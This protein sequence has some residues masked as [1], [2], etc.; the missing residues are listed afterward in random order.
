MKNAMI[1][2]HKRTWRS[3]LDL[4]YLDETS[5]RKSSQRQDLGAEHTATGKKLKQFT[6]YASKETLGQVHAGGF[7]HQMILVNADGSQTAPSK[8]SNA[9]RKKRIADSWFRHIRKFPTS[10]EN[11][12]IQHRLIFSMSR[13]LHDKLVESGINPDRVLQS[14]MKK[15]MG[16]FADRFHADDAIG[17]AYG[18]HHDTDNLHVHVALCPRTVK[19]KYVGCSMSHTA[20]SGNKNQMTFLRKCFERENHRW[21]ELLSSPVKMQQHLCERVDCDKLVFSP[22]LNQ[23]QM[24]V[25]RN[26]QTFEAIRLH[27]LYESIRHLEAAIAARRKQFAEEKNLRFLSRFTGRR[28][29]KLAQA[30][31]KASRAVE[32]RC[33]AEIQKLLFQT[34][35]QYRALHKRYCRLHG[36]TSHGHRN[37][38]QHAHRQ[39]NAL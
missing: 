19:G 12:V 7:L 30:V 1:F 23:Q 28:V 22:R 24:E 36:F 2:P 38:I 34:K 37:T 29:P 18:I 27:Q 25:V 35:T 33:L 32:R 26:T 5:E 31:S 39:Q 16:K 3:R 11:P 20:A 13:E 4:D 15:V 6:E 9:E 10:S 8:L 14:T 21:G 17:Y